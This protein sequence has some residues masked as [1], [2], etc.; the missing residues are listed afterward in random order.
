[1]NQIEIRQRSMDHRASGQVVAAFALSLLMLGWVGCCRTPDPKEGATVRAES[2]SPEALDRHRS[3]VEAWHEQRLAGL[4]KDDGWL[5]L[6]GLTWLES[7]ENSVGSEA[8]SAVTLPAAVPGQLGSLRMAETA[9]GS[10]VTLEL[11]EGQSIEVAGERFAGPQSLPLATDAQG[12]PTVVEVD[13]VSF[14]VIDRDG[15]LGVRIKDSASDV[16]RNFTD[17]ERFP[18]SWDWRIETH[19]VPRDEPKRLEIPTALGTVSEMGSPGRVTFEKDGRTFELDAFE[20]GDPSEV[21]FVFG[22]QTNSESTYGGGRLVYAQFEAGDTG[23]E[24]E[25]VVDFN[26]AYNPPCVFTP[27]ATCPLPTPEN[28]LALKVEAG[29]KVYGASAH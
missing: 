1:M 14:F 15:L 29:E 28:R 4:K 27:F 24:G 26:R 13:T 6:V 3:E 7:G 22:D 25:L 8:G 2:A 21:W 12:E 11:A 9:D 17:I 23:S 19:Y 10:S 18:V 16:R 20:T 5:T